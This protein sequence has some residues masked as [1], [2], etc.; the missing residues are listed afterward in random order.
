MIVIKAD[1]T[2]I[3]IVS[4]R[5]LITDATGKKFSKSEGNA[6]WLN[7]D[8]TSPYSVLNSDE[9]DGCGCVRFAKIFTFLSL[10]EIEEIRKHDLEPLP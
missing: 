6:V 9:C 3:H 7:A 2:E 5:A 4:W 8:K 1:K 10:D